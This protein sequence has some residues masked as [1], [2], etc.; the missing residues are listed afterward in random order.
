[1]SGRRKSDLDKFGTSPGRCTC[2]D[3][4]MTELSPTEIRIAIGAG[5][6]LRT[7]RASRASAVAALRKNDRPKF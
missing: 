4:R 6:N 3:N 1:M 2:F 7:K 5:Q